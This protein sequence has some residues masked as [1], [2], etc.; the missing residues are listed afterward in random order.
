[1]ENNVAYKIVGIGTIG[2]RMHHGIVR[3]LTNVRHIPNLKKNLISL[4]T[5]DSLGYKYPVKVESFGLTNAHW[6]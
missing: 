6:L 5:L 1:M 3:T 2:I 4:D